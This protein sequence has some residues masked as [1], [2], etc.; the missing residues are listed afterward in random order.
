VR[1]PVDIGT[2]R[3]TASKKRKISES[4]F[5]KMIFK[6]ELKNLPYLYNFLQIV[7]VAEALHSRQG[8]S[9]VSLLDPAEVK[10]A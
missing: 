8:F 9:S 3:I 7:L 1:Y 6:W 10:H 4:E 2:G 5:Q